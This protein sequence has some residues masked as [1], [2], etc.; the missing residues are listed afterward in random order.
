MTVSFATFTR[1][2]FKLLTVIILLIIVTATILHRSDAPELLKFPSKLLR[3]DAARFP[4]K[5]NL[6]AQTEGIAR[7]TTTPTAATTTTGKLTRRRNPQG[8]G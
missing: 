4:I 1:G 3:A 7:G 5:G 6:V 8:H 2:P